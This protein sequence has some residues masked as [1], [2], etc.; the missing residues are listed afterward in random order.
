VQYE[1]P[2]FEKEACCSQQM[3]A[4]CNANIALP[5]SPALVIGPFP[6]DITQAHKTRGRRAKRR[7]RGERA[8]KPRGPLPLGPLVIPSLVSCSGENNGLKNSASLAANSA[9]LLTAP[10]K[11]ARRSSAESAAR[12]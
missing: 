6:H 12:H 5:P 2:R 7:L 3:H 9:T 10:G 8:A 11:A 1:Y 4:R